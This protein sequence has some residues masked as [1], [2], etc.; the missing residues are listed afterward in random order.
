MGPL[1]E[2]QKYTVFFPEHG[3]LYTGITSVKDE[4][5]AHKVA[6]NQDLFPNIGNR[7][8]WSVSQ[9]ISFPMMYSENLSHNFFLICTYLHSMSFSD[10]DAKATGFHTSPGFCRRTAS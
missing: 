4:I 2:Y 1:K 10:Y 9:K 7:G 8:L 3:D 6:K 5:E